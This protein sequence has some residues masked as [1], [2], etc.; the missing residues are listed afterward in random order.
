MIYGRSA[1]AMGKQ[2]NT[3]MSD[4][5]N[6]NAS[7]NSPK[8]DNTGNPGSPAPSA[9]DNSKTIPPEIYNS[10]DPIKAQ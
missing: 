3:G 9:T 4:P 1:Q 7:S 8:F 5:A 10:S 6:P 2:P